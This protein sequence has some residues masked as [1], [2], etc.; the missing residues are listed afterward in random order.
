MYTNKEDLMVDKI[1][2]N[3]N[4]TDMMEEVSNEGDV[5]VD[6]LNRII[7]V[8]D[9]D[10]IA[11]NA[12]LVSNPVPAGI[13][14]FALLGLPRPSA[15]SNLSE[16]KVVV[17]DRNAIYPDLQSKFQVRLMLFCLHI[18]FEITTWECG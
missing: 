1:S 13:N 7:L 8:E 9:A 17:S 3:N 10:T 15:A 14:I 12:T 11:G 16:W 18:S 5:V 6:S 2:N 4:S